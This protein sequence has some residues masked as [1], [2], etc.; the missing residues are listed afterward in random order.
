[1]GEEQVPGLG[2]PALVVVAGWA[3]GIAGK[4]VTFLVVTAITDTSGG[5]S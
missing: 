5:P 1:M 4:K 3:D 2:Y